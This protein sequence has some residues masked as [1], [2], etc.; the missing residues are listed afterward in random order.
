[1]EGRRGPRERGPVMAVW[2]TADV[3]NSL[4]NIKTMV[5]E[6]PEITWR[7][8]YRPSTPISRAM[9]AV[10]RKAA[11]FPQVRGNDRLDGPELAG[12]EVLDFYALET[13]KI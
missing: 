8:L 4:Y 3:A 6:N 10:G 5:Y 2:P 11:K 12:A 1:V 9:D 7:T 13:K